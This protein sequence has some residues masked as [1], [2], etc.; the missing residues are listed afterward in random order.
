MFL[1]HIASI[2][3]FPHPFRFLQY[4][5]HLLFTY[6]T[7]CSPA[8]EARF[9][10]IVKTQSYRYKQFGFEMD[11]AIE[12]FLQLAEMVILIDPSTI[13]PSIELTSS[14]SQTII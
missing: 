14:P 10:P 3:V 9:E 5:K 8:P 1:R 13:T 4:N 11:I 2:P 12:C 6:Y 7:G